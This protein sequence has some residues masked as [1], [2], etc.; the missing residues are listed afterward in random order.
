VDAAELA[1]DWAYVVVDEI[2][3]ERIGLS[4][5]PW[6]GRDERGRLRFA[7]P[8]Q[9]Q[10]V[11]VAREAFEEFVR[12]N[13]VVGAVAADR[14]PDPGVADAL[15]EREV[16]IG[17]AFAIPR[18]TVAASAKGGGRKAW[19]G[20]RVYDISREARAAAKLAGAA[21]VAPPLDHEEAGRFLREA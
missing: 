1:S 16:R 19:A 6:P 21:A 11:G 13:R 20:A 14:E 8:E 4:A 5:S 15:R 12:K 3:D 10:L 7:D 9:D 2:V 17:D 18:R